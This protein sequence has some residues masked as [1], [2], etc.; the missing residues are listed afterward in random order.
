MAALAGP[1]LAAKPSHVP[2]V[3]AIQPAIGPNAGGTV[4]TITGTGFKKTTAVN[5][6]S[7]SATSFTVNSATSITA[8]SP[9]DTGTVDVTVTTTKG[10]TSATSP[11]DQ[12]KY[13]P[14]VC[15][16]A[17]GAVEIKSE[18]SA[19]PGCELLGTTVKGDVIVQPGG[20]LFTNDEE[21]RTTV[22]TGN[23][24]G[25]DAAAIGL[26]GHTMIGGKLRVKG[27]RE[28]VVAQLGSVSG[29]IEIEGGVA[30]AEF[31]SETVGGNVQVLNTSGEP[32]DLVA[33][34]EVL[35]G[36]VGGNVEL[37][38]NSLVSQVADEVRV[39]GTSVAG[40]VLIFN[41]T[42]THTKSP[43]AFSG[44]VTLRADHVGGSAELLNNTSLGLTEVSENV[45]TNTLNCVG[46][47]PPPEAEFPNTAKQ[48]LGQCEL[49]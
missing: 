33:S 4:V 28:R 36:T 31:D 42:E 30:S 26:A 5:F 35:G 25:S 7:V 48:K 6:G 29:N 18:I 17:I 2:A 32:P 37:G 34:V 22:I 21:T 19:G 3:T 12:F 49:L 11:A 14:F 20:D 10:S 27:T 13:A 44:A 39:V 41:N 43:L 24:E 40:N 23:V 16:G 9:A 15:D 8:T 38:N 47:V 45:V 46:N 1:A